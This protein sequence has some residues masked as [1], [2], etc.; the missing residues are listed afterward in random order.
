VRVALV[1]GGGGRPAP[2]EGSGIK[3]RLNN[4]KKR[5]EIIAK[6]EGRFIEG[7]KRDR[8]RRG[9]WLRQRA[10]SDAIIA[11]RMI[12]DRQSSVVSAKGKKGRSS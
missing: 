6:R 3:T 1:G 4:N 8:N 11:S 7:K 9:R 5:W 10:H 2:Q 12:K